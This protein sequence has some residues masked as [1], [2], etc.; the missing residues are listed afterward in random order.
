MTMKN[1]LTFLLVVL[2][3]VQ[4]RAELSID[5]TGARSEPMATALPV[6]SGK[7]KMSEYYAKKITDV[8]QSDLESSGLFRVIDSFAYLQTFKNIDDSPRFVDWQAISAEALI[9]GEV[10]FVSEKKINV[11][12]RLWDVFSAQEMHSATLEVGNKGWRRVAHVI[13]DTIYKRITGEEGY[14]DTRI[15][16]IAETGSAL[17]RIKRLAIM[18]Q[19]GENHQFLTDGLNLVLTPRFS[20]NMQQ[21]TYMSYYKDTPRVYLFDIETGKQQVVGDF[22]GMTFA[23]RFSPDGHKLIMSMARNGNSDIYEM[24]LDTRV[25]KRL[26]K[27]PEIETSPSYSPDGKY[28]VYN[29]D[30]SGGQQLYIM[31]SNGKNKHRISPFGNGRYATPVWS[32]R[33]DY[34]AFTKM[35][36]GKFYI[37]VMFPDGTGERLVAE[38]YLVE[39]PTWSPNGRILMYFR[40]QA[41][42]KKGIPGSTKIYAVD[43]TGYNERMLITPVDASDPAWSPLLS[44]H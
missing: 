6:F 8:I 3:S 27:G 5:I 21:I 34:I 25:V 7:N 38:G 41:P 32:P 15:V 28:I 4:A 37:G 18:D 13:A 36:N 16:Y 1:I 20:P 2:F 11:S 30:R 9:Q 12:F 42:N 14:F 40:Q 24:N 35:M 33:G 22:E 10:D 29:S 43:I 44:N 31:D 26:T 17:K 39:A 23:P 19:D